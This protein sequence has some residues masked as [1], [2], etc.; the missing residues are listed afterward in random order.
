MTRDISLAAAACLVAATLAGPAPAQT[1]QTPSEAREATSA[2]ERL[3]P[4]DPKGVRKVLAQ[5]LGPILGKDAEMWTAADYDSVKRAAV[6]CNKYRNSKGQMVNASSW[7]DAMDNAMREALP[8]AMEIARADKDTAE[9]RRKAPWMPRCFAILE[10][11]RDRKAWTDNSAKLFGKDFLDMTGEELDWSRTVVN[12]CRKAA[13]MIV[14]ARRQATR[15][16]IGT[17]TAAE[18]VYVIGKAEQAIKEQS[19]PNHGKHLVVRDGD[20][21]VPLAYISAESRMMVGIVN[22]SRELNRNLSASEIV[23]LNSWADDVMANQKS[24]NPELA[25]AR[26]VKEVVARQIFR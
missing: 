3:A 26:A 21:R 19:D 8:I 23:E 18:I 10:W 12:E 15:A 4:L 25:Y 1:A 22:R 6:E 20:R 24:S 17:L 7:V 5:M 11:R 16:K 13:D 14:F 9:I 2:C